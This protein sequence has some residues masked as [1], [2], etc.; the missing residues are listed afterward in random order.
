MWTI[1]N[2]G[3]KTHRGMLVRGV[4]AWSSGLME[5]RLDWRKEG[6]RGRSL[7]DGRERERDQEEMKEA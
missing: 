4:E 3:P 1:N 5:G 2:L 6:R 7:E